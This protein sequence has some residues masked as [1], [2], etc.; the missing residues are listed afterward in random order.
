MLAHPRAVGSV[1][2][3]SAA[4]SKLMATQL[5]PDAELIVEI[6]PGTGA[7]T[8]FFLQARPSAR[9]VL[10]EINPIFVQTLTQRFGKLPNVT[11]VE[12][13]AAGLRGI[14]DGLGLGA[15]DAVM[16]G[17]P[18]K[19]LPTEQSRAILRS[20]MQILRPDGR[21]VAIQ[22]TKSRKALFEEQFSRVTWNFELKNLPPVYV[23]VAQRESGAERA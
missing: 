22:Y 15:A 7:M 12:G 3:S 16:S 5:P 8:P 21:F 11:I 14:L 17:I 20:A 9:L 13:S 1:W 19:S 18:F 10:V 4:A 2:P 23:V 6:G